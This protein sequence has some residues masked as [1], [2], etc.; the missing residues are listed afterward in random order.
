MI[1]AS[2][3]MQSRRESARQ[4]GFTLIEL[5]VATAV[6]GV[7][8]VMAAQLLWHT[9]R[10]H[11]YTDERALRLG[12]VQRAMQIM[13]RDLL[14]FVYRPV[15]DELGDPIAPLIIG[16]HLPIEFTRLGWRNPLGMPR[17]EL[18]RVAYTIDE[19]TL[20][21]YYWNVLDRAEISEPVRQ[22]LLTDV[23]LLEISAID[24]SGNVHSFWPL[25]GELELDPE[26]ALAAVSVRMEVAPYGELVRVW[27]V[28]ENFAVMRP[29]APNGPGSPG[30]VP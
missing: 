30:E 20:Y 19:D 27:D 18:Q 8:G 12:D 14:Q 11:D 3:A 1:R 24:I 7:L 4:G 21:R 25:L 10:S 26:A 17:S 6:F 2:S 29:G 16:D 5:I 22:A 13:Q 15:R 9:S 23:H 28:P